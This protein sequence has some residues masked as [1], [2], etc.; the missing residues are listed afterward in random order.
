MREREAGT[1]T[2][3]VLASALAAAI[4]LAVVIGTGAPPAAA[5]V[6]AITGMIQI[7]L[8]VLLTRRASRRDDRRSGIRQVLTPTGP[9]AS[10]RRVVD[11]VEQ[12]L[13]EADGATRWTFLNRAWEAMTG[14][15]IAASIGQPVAASLHPD[16]GFEV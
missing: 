14:R 16:D 11:Q 3:T 13:F 4:A 15:E 5:W 9:E 2:G 1:A 6:V 8:V 12:V 7:A 10:Y